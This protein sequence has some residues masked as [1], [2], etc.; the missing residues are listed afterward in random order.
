MD[1]A[2]AGQ[3]LGEALVLIFNGQLREALPALDRVVDGVARAEGLALL[4]AFTKRALDDTIRRGPWDKPSEALPLFLLSW[5]FLAIG[6]LQQADETL[7]DA[8]SLDPHS[9]WTQA[10]EAMIVEAQALREVDA[11]VLAT[12]GNRWQLALAKAPDCPELNCGYASYLL[13]R[14][15]LRTARKHITAAIEAA[16]AWQLPHCIGAEICMADGDVAGAKTHLEA[17]S[18]LN[19]NAAAL[20][21]AKAIVT[22]RDRLWRR[23][24]YAYTRTFFSTRRRVAGLFS[25]GLVVTLQTIMMAFDAPSWIKPDAIWIYL[26]NGLA[27][28]PLVIGIW[29]QSLFPIRADRRG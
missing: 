21:A 14:G 24:L 4:V 15:A 18:R 3:R 26:V 9:P 13:Q 1:R 20:H 17:A 12:T 23:A 28:L 10:V 25:L 11:P 27:W 19:G 5:I 2:E 22:S 7:R 8:T 16:P 6:Q 29:G